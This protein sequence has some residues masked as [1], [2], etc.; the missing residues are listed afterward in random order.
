MVAELTLAVALFSD[1][2]HTSL[3]QVTRESKLPVRLLGI[4]MPLAILSG[5]LVAV[6]LLSEIPVWEAAI[7][8]TV[9]APT[10][11]NVAPDMVNSRLVPPR[12]R[13]ALSVESG[14]N[15]AV[16]LP[17]LVLL[18]PSRESSSMVGRHGSLLPPGRLVLAC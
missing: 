10:D 5:T 14:L 4:G 11:D 18:S 13:Q 8:A 1:A 12:V 9:L 17:L 3:K 15:D 16:C 7:L 2:T 6:L